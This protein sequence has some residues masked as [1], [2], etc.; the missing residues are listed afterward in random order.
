ML[1]VLMEYPDRDEEAQIL[2]SQAV[3]GGK[4]QISQAVSLED[5][6]NA[7]AEVD[8]VHFEPVL[9]E[10]V[11]DIVRATRPG[12][13]GSTNKPEVEALLEAGASPRAGIAIVLAAKAYALIKG[14]AFV[15]PADVKY[16]ARL[17]LPHRLVPSFEA[18]SRK[19]STVDIVEQILE[20]I[21]PP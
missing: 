2:D 7:S 19:V 17:V 14:R 18:D 15:I 3:T 12:V 13:G 20:R 16:A 5:I 8:T 4:P 11:L 9:K 6:K 10:Y 21:S 1:R